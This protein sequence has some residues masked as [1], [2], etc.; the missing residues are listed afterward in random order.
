MCK[1]LLIYCSSLLIVESC[2]ASQSASTFHCLHFF[3][4]HPIS[5]PHAATG[6]WL[7]LVNHGIRCIDCLDAHSGIPDESTADRNAQ[8]LVFASVVPGTVVVLDSIS[9]PYAF[10]TGTLV[11][12]V[13][14]TDIVRAQEPDW[15]AWTASL[16]LT[17]LGLIAVLAGNPLTLILAWAA[18][19][20]AELLVIFWHVHT[21]E[22]RR[23]VGWSFQQKSS[24]CS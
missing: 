19:D 20:F 12:A 6:F 13:V 21:S 8:H 9:W 15:S 24:A 23:R 4:N 3:C 1:Y 5:R 2:D 11:L 18:L 22:G 17:A 7:F 14:L 16:S 10:T